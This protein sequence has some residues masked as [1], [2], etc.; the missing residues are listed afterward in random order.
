MTI[1]ANSPDDYIEKIEDTQK[2]A[3]VIKL[4]NMIRN[5]IPVG[6]EEGILYNMITF[7]VPH[8]LYPAGYH[9]DPK[10][11]LPFISIAAQ[12]NFVAVYHMGIYAD[13]GLLN[14]F[15]EEHQK[16]V[17]GK[18]DMGKSCIRYKNPDKIPSDLIGELAAKMTP[19]DWISLYEKAFRSK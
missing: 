8:S 18:L 15:S 1:Q 6:F 2:Q 3:A 4:R 5:N 19:I 12:K 10:L 16:R 17:S 13:Q 7:Y 14:W 9:C 11:P